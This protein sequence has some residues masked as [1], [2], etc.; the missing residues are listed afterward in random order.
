MRFSILMCAAALIINGISQAAVSLPSVT[1]ITV[2][3]TSIRLGL[4]SAAP[5][6]VTV[7]ELSPWSQV[8]SGAVYSKSS[9]NSLVISRYEGSRDRITSGF[10]VKQGQTAFPGVRFA[11][12]FG[13]ISK[14][15]AAYPKIK[16]IKGLQVTDI[17]DAV[18]LGVR[19]AATNLNQGDFMLSGP[20]DGALVHEMNGKRFY[21]DGNQVRNFDKRLKDLTDNH[22]LVTLILLNSKNWAKSMTPDMQAILLHPKYDSEGLIS[23]FNLTNAKSYEYYEAFI[24]FVM[25]RYADPK[26]P[27][28]RAW[29]MIIGNE[30][31]SHWVW[32]NAGLITAEQ[33]MREYTTAMRTAYLIGAKYNTNLRVYI[34]LTHMFNKPY[35]DNPKQTISARRC[36]E[37]LNANCKSDG[38]FPWSV[39]YHPYPEDLSFPDFWND[40]TATDSLDTTTRITFKNIELLPKFLSQPQFLYRGKQRKI[41]LSEQGFNS[42]K[43]E[44]SEQ[45][46]AAAYALAYDKIKKCPGIEAFILHAH[47]D[48]L[49]EF[50]LNLGLWR[51]DANNK[52]I[53]KKPI[54][55]VFRDIDGPRGPEILAWAKTFLDKKMERKPAEKLY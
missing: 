9:G 1:K 22:I 11:T 24:D 42:R 20:A 14:Y 25:N 48:N 34:S 2:D 39:A 5:S 53:S 18:K 28:G 17:P 31:D 12:D 50:G 37:L 10:L 32:G 23:A 55:D 33:Y 46:Q 16:S 52:P 3:K 51:V 45:F 36:L 15:Q 6:D 49:G 30:I 13:K 4:S 54:Y 19:H 29:G 27:Y 26:A 43:T 47:Q 41:I 35:N 21:F 40:A 7:W 44:E 8:P 38:D